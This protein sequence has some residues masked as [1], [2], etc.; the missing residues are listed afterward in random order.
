VRILFSSLGLVGHIH[1]LVPLAM[2]LRTRGHD[3]CWA[4]GPAGCE[5]VKRAG[6][7]AV[8]AGLSQAERWAQYRRRHPEINELP[9]QERPEFR[10]RE[11][12]R[13]D[14]RAGRAC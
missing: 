10:V 12:V 5:R 6:F 4:T 1:P 8:S 7:D 14:Q 11:A 9:P 3:V 2:A 13:R